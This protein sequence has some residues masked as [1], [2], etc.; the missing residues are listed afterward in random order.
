MTFPKKR[1]TV[2]RKGFTDSVGVDAR[3]AVIGLRT[4]MTSRSSVH[5]I[6]TR[7]SKVSVSFAARM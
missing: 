1:I 4:N 6:F 7:T 2:P 5:H 3:N